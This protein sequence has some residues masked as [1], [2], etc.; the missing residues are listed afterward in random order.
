MTVHNLL[1]NESWQDRG[2]LQ[3]CAKCCTF[4]IGITLNAESIINT[5]ISNVVLCIRLILLFLRQTL[6]FNF[7]LTSK[8]IVLPS[9]IVSQA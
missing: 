6:V 9:S 7:Q 5:Q 8:P 4:D 1:R 2:T 3:M